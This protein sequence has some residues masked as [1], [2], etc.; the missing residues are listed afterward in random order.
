MWAWRAELFVVQK[1]GEHE[2]PLALLP[3]SAQRLVRFAVA[4]PAVPVG[5]RALA[6]D[7]RPRLVHY[8]AMWEENASA[9]AALLDS[10]RR[11]PELESLG[12]TIVCFDPYPS[13]ARWAGRRRLTLDIVLDHDRLLAGALPCPSVPYT[14]LLDASGRVLVAQPGR[15]D[16]WS[17]ETRATLRHALAPADAPAGGAPAHAS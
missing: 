9:Q 6:T 15:V 12:V 13:L 5:V 4:L 11:D 10:L 17:A 7:G 14:Y 2:R 3:D 1:P 16:W 8:F